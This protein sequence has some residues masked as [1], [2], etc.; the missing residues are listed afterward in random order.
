M[1]RNT[2][3]FQSATIQ[4]VIASGFSSLTIWWTYTRYILP[5]QLVPFLQPGGMNDRFCQ[6]VAYME[7]HVDLKSQIQN[8][9]IS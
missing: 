5:I 8:L 3:I 4:C 7:V 6:N 9:N 2:K 1:G